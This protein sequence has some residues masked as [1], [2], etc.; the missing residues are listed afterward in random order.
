MAIPLEREEPAVPPFEH[1]CFC[2]QPTP[3]WTNIHKRKPGEQVACCQAC[4]PLYSQ[5]EV[6]TKKAWY[7]K[8]VEF[9]KYRF[10]ARRHQI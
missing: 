4:A 6:P 2:R 10:L 1:C 9:E 7:N 8:E 3:F 5:K